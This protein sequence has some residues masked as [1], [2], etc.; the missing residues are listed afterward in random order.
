MYGCVLGTKYYLNSEK[1]LKQHYLNMSSQNFTNFQQFSP[2][3]N[4]P[5]LKR[6]KLCNMKRNLNR[7]PKEGSQK[8]KISNYSFQILNCPSHQKCIFKKHVLK[9]WY[10]SKSQTCSLENV[11]LFTCCF[12]SRLQCDSGIYRRLSY[13]FVRKQ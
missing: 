1:Q 2:D 3:N 9:I 10:E 13:P 7:Q 4:K 5:Y 11:G 8:V 12:S 6:Q